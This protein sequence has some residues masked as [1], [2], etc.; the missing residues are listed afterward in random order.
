MTS[1][2][3]PVAP[4]VVALVITAA[5]WDWQT[6]RI[7]N[8]LVLIA[9]IVALPMQI[10]LHGAIGGGRAWLLGC[11]AG[12]A[13]LLP[14]YMTRTVGAGDV[15]LMAAIGA[16]CGALVAMEI[17]VFA[18][19]V[20]GIWAVLLL[21]RRKQ[22]WAGVSNTMTMLATAAGGARAGVQH[23]ESMRALSMG[24]MPFGVAIAIGTLGALMTGL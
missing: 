6:R 9:L 15:K 3:F 12:G 22:V 11:L 2:L 13:M 17:A 14:G 23:G 7:P 8:W 19:V 24:R 1:I 4:C 5:V 18:S 20:G 16:L 21:L 10:F